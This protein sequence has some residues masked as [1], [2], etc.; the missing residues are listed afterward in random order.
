M[1]FYGFKKKAT[2]YTGTRCNA[3]WVQRYKNSADYWGRE[4]D[5]L[6]LLLRRW[7]DASCLKGTG[8]ALAEAGFRAFSLDAR[9]HGDSDWAPD[10][11]YEQD[12][13][14]DDLAAVVEFLA[15]PTQFWLVLR[16]VV[17]SACVRLVMVKLM[18]EPLFWLIWHQD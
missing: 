5:P 1:S 3:T 4:C 13:M 7:S 18:R 15:I 2:G 16:W 14:V 17:V 6:V 8:E 10:G 9:G 11:D 12:G